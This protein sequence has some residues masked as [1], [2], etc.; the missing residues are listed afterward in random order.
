MTTFKPMLKQPLTSASRAGSPQR[1]TTFRWRFAARW[2][3][4]LLPVVAFLSLGMGPCGNEPIGTLDGGFPQGNQDAHA[5]NDTQ[6]GNDAQST[7]DA[8]HDDRGT[9]VDTS[10]DHGGA[11]VSIDG[12]SDASAGDASPTSCSYQG[13]QYPLNSKFPANDGCNTCT[14]TSSGIS[15]TEAICETCS[16]YGLLFK[17]GETIMSPDGCEICTCVADKN[18]V[19]KTTGCPVDAGAAD[20]AVMPIPNVCKPGLDQTCNDDPKLSSI[21]GKC[22]SD[23]HCECAVGINPTTGKC[24]ALSPTQSCAYNG[25]VY[26]VGDKFAC[27]DGCNTCRCLAPG[28]VQN[29][30]QIPCNLPPGSKCSFDSVY[31]YSR[32]VVGAGVQDEVTLGSNATSGSTYT[33]KRTK[34]VDGGLV[35]RSCSAPWP[36]CGGLQALDVA[37]IMKDLQE[38][39]IEMALKGSPVQFGRQDS[40]AGAVN[41]VFTRADGSGFS[42]GS[43]CA[44]EV[45]CLEIPEPVSNLWK[46]LAALDAQQLQSTTCAVLKGF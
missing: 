22:A 6:A 36:M 20:G 13:K 21:L 5:G 31:F 29:D 30:T 4:A 37:D 32:N 34:V 19:C 23:G 18:V 14:C 35:T 25:M 33:Y 7:V 44:G 41:L 8:G 28:Q 42:V 24:T 38:P 15:C 1:P 40:S 17:I 11:E 45:G 10:V 2:P 43:P 16:A 9:A 39:Q 46:D 27:A 3:F 26:A 12:S